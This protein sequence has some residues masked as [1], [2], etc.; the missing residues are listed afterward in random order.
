MGLF[1]FG[2]KDEA[3][4]RRGANA[5]SARGEP[6]RRRAERSGDTSGKDAA[7]S[8]D[9]MLLDPTL[10]EK[11]RAR[12]RLV[13]AIALVFAAVVVLPMVLDSHPKPVTDDIAIDIP[14]RP[15]NVP[16]RK[17]DDAADSASAQ[18]GVAP[19]SASGGPAAAGVTP[20]A[21]DAEAGT[22]AQSTASKQSGKPTQYAT[23]SA[24]STKPGPSSPPQKPAAQMAPGTQAAQATELARQVQPSQATKP[25]AQAAKP[26]QMP[27]PSAAKADSGTPATPPGAR[28]AVQLGVFSDDASARRWE[29]KLKAAGVPA[30]VENR[31]EAD[32]S[33]RALLRAG[34]FPD[35]AA[36]SAAIAKVREAGLT[37]NAAQ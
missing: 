13:G 3:P 36:A 12:R 15:A 26:I 30:Y 37:A 1:S 21:S 23:D 11:Q 2:N 32:G 20:L 34:P 18:A 19:D 14:S 27:A 25:Q 24:K 8:A 6:R 16:A 22:A 28:F 29:A 35:R 4:R 33:K 9:A 17:S 10:P 5:K 31:K 7:Y